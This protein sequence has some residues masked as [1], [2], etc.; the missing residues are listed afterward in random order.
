LEDVKAAPC[1]WLANTLNDPFDGDCSDSVNAT[2]KISVQDLTACPISL[3][4][5]HFKFK[6]LL[7]HFFTAPATVI[8]IFAGAIAVVCAML[9]F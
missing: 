5:Q 4:C 1:T 7:I 9:S 2:G 6:F 3:Q 8:E